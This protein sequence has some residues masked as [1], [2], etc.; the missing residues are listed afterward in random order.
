M[1][2]P[3]IL[4]AIL[5][6]IVVVLLAVYLQTSGQLSEAQGKLAQ[7]QKEAESLRQQISALQSQISALQGKI[8]ELNKTLSE[9]AQI[10]EQKA[11]TPRGLVYAAVREGNRLFAYVIDPVTNDLIAKVDL[12]YTLS[13]EVRDALMSTLLALARPSTV[14]SWTP[15]Y[16]VGNL[17]YFIFLFENPNG[18]YVAFIDRYTFKDI[19]IVKTHDKYT[20]Q[21]GGIT[22]DGKYLIISQ[23]QA[24]RV[25]IIDLSTFTTVAAVQTDAN[26]CDAAPSPDG[27]YVLIPVRADQ[28]PKK[29]EYALVLEVPTG[30]EVARYY[31]KK[32]GEQAYTEPSMTYWSYYKSSYGILQGEARPYEAVLEIDTKGGTIKLIKEVSYPS[33]AFMAIENPASEEVAVVVSGYGLYIRSLPPAYAVMKDVKVVPDYLKTAVQGTYSQDGRYFYLAGPGGLVVIDTA[34]WSVVKYFKAD[35][36]LW[37][38]ALPSGEWLKIYGK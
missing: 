16:Y 19:K 8:A 35:A 37:V 29:P 22:P 32:P 15:R 18:S 27:K 11:P 1:K 36:A 31:F 30:K 5:A 17:P 21:Y 28:D 13:K 14:E 24:Q 3:T 20:R 26:P 10:T 12:N 33:I 2:A 4:A 23:R 7:A 34:T 25:V 38:V 9:K 6:V